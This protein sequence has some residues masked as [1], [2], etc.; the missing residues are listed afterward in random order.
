MYGLL[1]DESR[2]ILCF[3]LNTNSDEIDKFHSPARERPSTAAKR[4]LGIPLSPREQN[5]VLWN[6]RDGWI[7]AEEVKKQE[8]M[9]LQQQQATS[10]R[11]IFQTNTE[12]TQATKPKKQPLPFMR[13]S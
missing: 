2:L 9:R 3:L 6:P 12:Q 8:A 7:S 4:R 5:P 1:A 10:T 11:P 13:K